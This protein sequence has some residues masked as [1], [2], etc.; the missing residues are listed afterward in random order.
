MAGIDRIDGKYLWI[1]VS[2]MSGLNRLSSEGFAPA[3]GVRRLF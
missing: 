2:K 3:R 1:F